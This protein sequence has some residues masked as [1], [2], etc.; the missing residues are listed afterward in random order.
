MIKLTVLEAKHIHYVLEETGRFLDDQFGADQE[1]DGIDDQV[2][3]AVDI[4][5][6]ALDNVVDE[7]IPLDLESWQSGE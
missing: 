6:G 2:D 1:L 3:S 4:L 7:E 5:R